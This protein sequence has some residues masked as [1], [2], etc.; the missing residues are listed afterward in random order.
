MDAVA[1]YDD[2]F[3][4]CDPY[5]WMYK[6]G[7]YAYTDGENFAFFNR[8]QPHVY[9]GH[10]FFVSRGKEAK[11]IADETLRHFFETTDATVIR[12][13]TPL[14]LRNARW[15]SRQLG[16]KSFGVV[17]TNRG[18]C[19]MFLLYKDEYMNRIKE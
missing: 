9:A 1:G 5:E 10:Y 2:D 6:E 7:N 15:M 11:E 12:G 17:N 16:F 14:Q 19:E 3:Y 18:P 13:M 8:V 4:G